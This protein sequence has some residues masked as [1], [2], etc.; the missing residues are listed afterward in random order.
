MKN[1][2]DL[3]IRYCLYFLGIYIGIYKLIDK[4]LID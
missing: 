4:F 2:N 1:I 3:D